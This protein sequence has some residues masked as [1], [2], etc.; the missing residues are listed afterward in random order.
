MQRFF[1]YMRSIGI[2]VISALILLSYFNTTLHA[3]WLH[4]RG[5]KQTGASEEKN[6]PE[7]WSPNTPGKENLVW[8]A[9]FGCRSTPLIMKGK[10]YIINA[11]GETPNVPTPKEKEL[12]GERVMCLDAL[13]GKV[14]WEQIFNVF[15]S[16]IVTNRLGWAPLAADPVK[17]T[18][19][20]HSTG[21]FLFC[22]DADTGAI[23]WQRQLTEEFGRVTGYG[24]RVGGGPIF[25]EGLVIVGI[26]NSSWG[27]HGFGLNRIAA[28][29]GETGNVVWWGICPG[30]IKGTYYSNPI[31]HEINGE[32]LVITGGADG[33]IHAFQLHTGKKVWSYTFASG[34]IN[35]S[36]VAEGNLVYLSHGE[37]NPEGSKTGI[38]RV[39]CLDASQI[40]NGTPKLVW[41]FSRGIRFGLASLALADGKL[42]IPDDAAKL[43]CFDA[44]KGKL[45]WKVNYGTTSRGAPV[46][47]DGKIYLSETNA[48]FHIIK[49]PKD[50][51]VPDEDNDFYT[52][53]FRNKPGASGFVECNSTP[54]ISDGRVYFGNRDEIYC[55]ANP[56]APALKKENYAP[57][58][59]KAAQ[60]PVTQLQIYPA[61]VG[62][63][64]GQSFTFELRGYNAK[65]ERVANLPGEASWSI[66]IPPPPK[67][68]TT[69]PPKLDASIDEKT[70]KITINAKKPS[71]QGYVD[72]KIGMLT[73]RARIRV[74]PQIPYSQNFEMIPVGAVPTGWVN[75]QA[76]YKVIEWTEEGKKAKVLMKVNNNPRP[77][78]ARANAYITAPNSSNYTI[79]ADVLGKEVRG[80]LPDF[81]II[82]NRYTLYL[83]GKQT[84]DGSLSIK[85]LTWEAL[86]PRPEGRV[87]ASKSFNWKQNTWYRLKLSVE[88]DGD[89]GIIR[90]KV[91]E[92]S[93]K[94]PNDWT[95]EVHDP[96][97][98]KTGA[99]GLY[100]YV[101]NATQDEPGVEIYY[102]NISIV[103]NKKSV[104]R[105]NIK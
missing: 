20:A 87:Q 74:V 4:W 42:Y 14:L 102:D 99:A 64:P 24:G 51:S 104:S 89:K 25:A 9:P 79:E 71:Q 97:V 52:V 92:R 88:S 34:V 38:G 81:G 105:A 8:K 48:K 44:K 28:F 73:N 67:G 82:A 83:D 31:V 80:K 77:P 62:L 84:E 22:F 32:K 58:T 11:Y 33:A 75:T 90:G 47:A 50:G 7:S 3:D 1:G 85:L 86:T 55:I 91:W 37:E 60:G 53:R 12:I 54:S 19:F 13:N 6:L 59:G 23:K 30:A 10:V 2:S 98:N 27:D 63:S 101:V 76:K 17:N 36:P 21:G 29:D 41:E 56:N 49:L 94:E 46:I 26:V 35:P 103:P 65:G 45:L 96:R 78:L 43:Y 61:E 93:Q 39:I 69:I 15:H 40:T 68:S 72:A 70:G 16:D 66:G 5:P 100:G 57:G 95:L 18:I